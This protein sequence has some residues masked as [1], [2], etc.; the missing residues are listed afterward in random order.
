[1]QAV[2]GARWRSWLLVIISGL[3]VLIALGLCVFLL[4]SGIIGLAGNQMPASQ[5]I[6]ALNLA[7][8]SALVALLCVPAVVFSI[9]EL[10]GRAN[11]DWPARRGFLFASLALLAWV[12][13]VFLFKPLETSQLAW[14]FLP[15]LV[16]LATVIPLWWYLESGRRGL[17]SG[18]PARI[19]GV[20]SFSLVVTIPFILIIEL[21]L[22]L[23][24]LLV[25]SI[26]VGTQPELTLQIENF[27]RLFSDFANNSAVIQDM[28][29]RLF[30]QPGVMAV[31]LAVTAGVIPLI[32][33]LFKPLAVWL[34]AGERLTPSQGFIAGI[35][36]GASFA[37]YENLT[38]LS[39]AGG[40]D[41]T[42]ILLARVG[43]GL[44]HV[45]TAGLT[46]WG[47]ASFWQDRKNF[48]RLIAAYL[49]AVFLHSLWNA[50]GVISGIAPL[51]PLPAQ[52]PALIAGL[53][54]TASI[55]LYILVG[56]NLVFL[57]FI[58]LRLR[59]ENAANNSAPGPGNT[60]SETR[61][62]ELNSTPLPP[63]GGTTL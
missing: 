23:G 38:A 5:G 57:F 58:N 6:S 4:A 48:G 3:G 15:P 34:L 8:A 2:T 53:G 33:E 22:L 45:V 47:L 12:G 40:G 9:R 31:T 24:L 39:A 1:M 29:S 27:A 21:L 14:L 41:G 52:A 17:S 25:F 42:F 28:I 37:L 7:W 62:P 49:L 18:S 56:F 35:F 50:A 51:L 36:S 61:L 46:G 55:T 32:E 26:Y 43:T 19:W 20:I 63:I 59:K 10:S 11:L 30:Q 16:I 54:K 60:P 44:L 13:L